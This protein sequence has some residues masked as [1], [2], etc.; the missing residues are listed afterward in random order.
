MR[1]LCTKQTLRFVPA[2]GGEGVTVS[3]KPGIQEV[4]DWLRDT[5]T[6]KAAAPAGVIVDLDNLGASKPAAEVVA[7]AIAPV[8]A[9]DKLPGLT[10]KVGGKARA[11]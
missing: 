3:P 8:P 1:L 4:P 6:F 7:P 11:A 5:D 10:G 2:G 9:E